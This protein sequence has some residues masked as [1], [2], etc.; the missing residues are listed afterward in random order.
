MMKLLATI[1][2]NIGIITLFMGLLYIFG[3]SIELIVPWQELTNVF[4]IMRRFWTA[5]NWW[6]DI[7]EMIILIGF[8]LLI[9]AGEWVLK[10]GLFPIDYFLK[11]D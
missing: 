6:W 7:T 11:K 9:D 3:K 5:A 1:A 8:S 2:K 4:I 10:A